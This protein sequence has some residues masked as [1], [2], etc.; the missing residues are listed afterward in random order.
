MENLIYESKPVSK[1]KLIK[2]GALLIFAALSAYFLRP[3]FSESKDASAIIVGIFSLLS[4]F[5]L[6][7]M[8]VVAN[9]KTVRGKNWRE[10]TYHLQQ[11][12]IE[13]L[14]HQ[15]TFYIYLI[16]LALA[17]VNSL[18]AKWCPIAQSSIEHSLLFFAIIGVA[19]SFRLPAVLKKRHEIALKQMIAK[20]REKEL[21]EDLKRGGDQS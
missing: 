3:W 21:A 9:D 6:A 10:Q 18:S 12:S 5:L 15:I 2:L 19:L 20:N 1:K 13:L 11:I 17:F 16:T 14:R 4:G 8:A 7:V